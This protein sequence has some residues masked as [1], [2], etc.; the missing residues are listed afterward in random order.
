[1]QTMYAVV[2]GAVCQLLLP[3]PETPLLPDIR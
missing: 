1:M 3:P 2:D